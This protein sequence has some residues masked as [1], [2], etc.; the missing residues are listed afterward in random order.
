MGSCGTCSTQAKET[1]KKIPKRNIKNVIAI[2]S[3]KG[4]VGKS[5]VTTLLAKELK[6]LGYS[7]GI[8]DAD[9]TGPSIPRLMNVSEERITIEDK[10]MVPVTSKEG[11]KVISLNLV[12]ED[13]Y[14][15]VVWRGPVIAQAVMQFWNE[16]VWGD[17]DYL[18]IDMP[19]GTG[20]VP[21]TVMKEFNLKG[22]VMVSVPQDMISMIVIKAVKMARK[23][24]VEILGLI[25]NMSYITCDCCDNKIYMSDE[26]ETEKFLKEIDVELLGELPMMKA[27]SK[28]SSGEN[29]YSTEIFE[30]I[31]KRVAE[32][33]K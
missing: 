15:P 24:N 26:K 30:N 3:G 23:M 11:I 28:M 8:M 9:I 5:T 2:M 22:L 13:E 25:E 14:E 7:V 1:N 32:K 31:A 10:F 16:T 33:T 17:L 19:P 20:D 21:L 6:K 18:L 29:F 4:G 12:T 27:I